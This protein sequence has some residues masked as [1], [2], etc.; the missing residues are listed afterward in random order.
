MASDVWFAVLPD[1]AAGPGAARALRTGAV[2][3][4][5]HA[6]GRPWL[7][8][9]WPAGHVR[10]AA[11][12]GARLAVIGRCPVTAE[13]LTARLR[14]LAGVDDMDDVLAGLPGSFHAVASA[15]GEVRVRG[16]AS[17]VRRVFHARVAGVTVAAS[18]ADTLA[19]ATGAEVDERQLALRLL[20]APPP[21]P[22]DDDSPWRGV[23][24]LPSDSALLL[25]SDGHAAVRRWWCPPEPEVPAAEGAAEVRRAL[26]VAVGTCTADGGAVSADLSGGIDST[27][28]CFLAARGPARLVTFR[29]ESVDPANDDT[30]WAG[31][32]AAHLPRAEHVRPPAARDPLWFSGLGGPSGVRAGADEPG[33]WVRDNARLRTLAGLLT[34]RGSRLHLSGGGGD[35]LFSAHSPHLYDFLRTDPVA[36]LRRVRRQRALHRQPLRPL[37]RGLADRSSFGQWL[38]AWAAHLTDE[39]GKAPARHASAAAWGVLLRMPPWATQDAVRAAQGVLCEAAARV[40]EPLSPQRGQHAALSAVQSCGRAFRQVDQAATRLGLPC[41]APYLDDGVIE[42]ALSVRVAERSAPDVYKPVL[43]TAMRGLVPDSLLARSTKGEYSADFHFAL[44]H[45]RDALE[46]L[47]DGSRLAGAGL[48]DA[49]ALRAGLRHPHLTPE[50]MRCLDTTVACEVWLRG[51]PGPGGPPCG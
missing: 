28:L 42:A 33:S 9:G 19:G 26:S 25:A 36:A 47:L 38:A 27:S 3:T 20:S 14:R 35:E 32:A 13:A 10:V 43:A 50:V 45:N 18:R 5:R 8:G 49:K 4:V 40:P 46:E 6:S 44:R 41:A 22:L 51:L 37:M 12:G 24:A 16:S 48:L 29:W 2:Q 31:R 30:A 21:Y 34:D 39:P 15:G 23:S 1:G 7:V 17:A 11:A